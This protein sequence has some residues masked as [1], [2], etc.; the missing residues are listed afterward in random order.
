MHSHIKSSNYGFSF[1]SSEEV[2]GAV[3]PGFSDF[4][5]SQICVLFYV[6]A[7]CFCLSDPVVTIP[8]I[9][10]V[11]PYVH[12]ISL[13]KEPPGNNHQ[14]GVIMTETKQYKREKS[15]NTPISNP[16]LQDSSS[17]LI[18]G[19][20]ILSS[21]FLRDYADVPILR[22]IRPEDL[23][24]VSERYVP[25][26]GAERNSDTVKYVDISKYLLT[27]KETD[28]TSLGD[29]EMSSKSKKPLP[30]P[31]YI[32]SLVEHKTE[33]EYNVI[34]QILRYTIHIWEDYE[35]EME[36]L[37]AGISR[38]KDF[39]YPPVLPIV[40]YEGTRRW[41]ACTDLAD[42]ILCGEQLGKYL[43]HFRYQLV[44]LQDYSNDELLAN[45]D[46]ISLAMLINKIQTKED[47]TAF[48]RLPKEQL[49]D[50]LKDT[51]EYLLET[52]AKVLR[53]LLYRMEQPEETVEHTVSKIKERKMGMLFEHLEINF[54]E[55]QRKT[56]KAR[57]RADV[58]EKKADA[59]EKKADAAE[60]KA[61]AAQIEKE[62][63]KHI[64]H[65]TRQGHS[66]EE[67]L[68]SLMQQFSLSPEQ[69]REKLAE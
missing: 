3:R 52:L 49:D 54:A 47:L 13:L 4:F 20:N 21:Q 17:K 41:S 44:K 35:K 37:H 39:Q 6:P 8:L 2:C 61:T 45:G 23:T 66:D 28:E 26:Y 18:F 43:P 11:G 53:A 48:D 5:D 19:D 55:E 7:L 38:R 62:I 36:K 59:A 56:E 32:I 29:N 40:Y 34:M 9:Y 22:R 67:I 64:T 65:M 63:Y 27:P 57:K 33:V 12:H 46:E 25:L 31:L 10:A 16:H 14:K 58:A 24:D 30:L 50:I 69:A 1:G 68:K 60:R 42:R 15:N 51:P